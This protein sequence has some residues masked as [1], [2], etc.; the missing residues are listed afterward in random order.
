MK[1]DKK[2]DSPSELMDSLRSI[3][4]KLVRSELVRL[5]LG[6]SRYMRIVVR[7][8]KPD[9]QTEPNLSGAPEK[10]RRSISVYIDVIR[11][12]T[13]EG[14]YAGLKIKVRISDH[15]SSKM[16]DGIS[17]DGGLTEIFILHSDIGDAIRIMSGDQV[18]YKW[19]SLDWEEHLLPLI[20]G[21][22]AEFPGGARISA[23]KAKYFVAP[24]KK[25]IVGD[26]IND[27]RDRIMTAIHKFIHQGN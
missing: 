5:A 21:R 9:K 6:D 3:T 27:I 1:V 14:Q 7:K 23:K 8:P 19:N 15:P 18:V 26:T 12:L 11:F 24:D 16:K 20:N 2:F 4:I 13:D 22:D 25:E 17:Q 10:D